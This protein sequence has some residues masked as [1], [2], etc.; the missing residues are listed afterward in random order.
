MRPVVSV[1]SLPG[2][3]PLGVLVR[4]Q[5]GFWLLRSCTQCGPN[6]AFVKQPD[7]IVSGRPFGILRLCPLTSFVWNSSS[8]VCRPSSVGHS[9]VTCGDCERELEKFCDAQDQTE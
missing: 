1:R 8:T 5:Y 7:G 2:R 6:V 4:G 3:L 9:R